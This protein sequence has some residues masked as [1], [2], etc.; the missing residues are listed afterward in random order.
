MFKKMKLLMIIFIFPLFVMSCNKNFIENIKTPLRITK[1]S[2][3][4]YTNHLIRS[5]KDSN[6]VHISIFYTETGK[7][8]TFSN[9]NMKK[10]KEFLE[11]IKP[12]NF[13]NENKNSI[14]LKEPKYRLTISINQKNSFIINVFNNSYLTIHP[15]DGVYSPD[16]L[17]ISNFHEGINLYNLCDFIIKK[18]Y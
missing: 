1:P 10:F 15:W 6:N 12:V 14:D 8:K 2:A 16:V 17:D 7:N 3:N 13:L 5:I 9:E 4:F 11:Y 18:D